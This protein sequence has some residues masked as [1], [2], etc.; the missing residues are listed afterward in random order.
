MSRGSHGRDERCLVCLRHVACAHVRAHERHPESLGGAGV[1]GPHPVCPPC[2]QNLLENFRPRQTLTGPGEISGEGQ[3]PCPLCRCALG[4]SRRALGER[5]NLEVEGGGGDEQCSPMRPPSAI[6]RQ[7]Q[8][9]M[10]AHDRESLRNLWKEGA[11]REGFLCGP[12]ALATAR[13]LAEGQDAVADAAGQETAAADRSGQTRP[14]C[15]GKLHQR[16]TSAQRRCKRQRKASK[17][18]ELTAATPLAPEVLT[19]AACAPLSAVDDVATGEGAASPIAVARMA[20]AAAER[21]ESM[22]LAKSADAVIA[23]PVASP[24]DPV[25]VALTGTSPPSEAAARSQ[26]L[27]SELLASAERRLRAAQA[28]SASKSSTS[29]TQSATSLAATTA[30]ATAFTAPIDAVAEVCADTIVAAV[31]ISP[32]PTLAKA[33]SISRDLLSSDLLASAE[34]RLRAALASVSLPFTSSQL[35]TSVRPVYPTAPLEAIESTPPDLASPSSQQ[36]VAAGSASPL[37]EPSAS[38]PTMLEASVSLPSPLSQ[39]FVAAVPSPVESCVAKTFSQA[40]LSAVLPCPSH[41]MMIVAQGASPDV[42]QSGVSP[43]QPDAW[44]PLPF[45]SPQQPISVGAPSPAASLVAIVLT[46]LD[47]SASLSSPTSQH[48]VGA[49]SAS[50]ILEPSATAPPQ[51]NA[52]VSLPSPP[53]QRAVALGLASTPTAVEAPT[54]A[55]PGAAAGF[56]TRSGVSVFTCV[57]APAHAKPKAAAGQLAGSNVL[58]SIGVAAPAHTEPEAASGQLTSC[59]VSVS[60]PSPLSQQLVVAEA[61]SCEGASSSSAKAI[62]GLGSEAITTNRGLAG[63]APWQWGNES[64]AERRLRAALVASASPLRAC[65]AARRR[66]IGPGSLAAPSVFAPPLAAA[67]LPAALPVAAAAAL[68]FQF[69]E[70]ARAL[71][72]PASGQNSAGAVPLVA[73]A[74]TRLADDG[75]PLR[76]YARRREG[77]LEQRRQ[78]LQRKVQH[79]M[80]EQQQLL[81]KQL[82]LQQ[83]RQSLRQ[84]RKA[85]QEAQVGGRGR[86]TKAR[87]SNG[88]LR[89]NALTTSDPAPLPGPLPAPPLPA[90]PLLAPPLSA[91]LV[92]EPASATA[93]PARGCRQALQFSP[94]FSQPGESLSP[95]LGFSLERLNCLGDFVAQ[96]AAIEVEVEVPTSPAAAVLVEEAG[97]A[98]ASC[99]R[100]RDAGMQL[101]PSSPLVAYGSHYDRDLRGQAEADGARYDRELLGQAEELSRKAGGFSLACAMRLW[102]QVEEAAETKKR[103]LLRIAEAE[104]FA[105]D[106]QARRFLRARLARLDARAPPPPVAVRRDAATS[107]LSASPQLSLRLSLPPSAAEGRLGACVGAGA[108]V[109]PASSTSPGVVARAKARGA[110]LEPTQV[111]KTMRLLQDAYHSLAEA[112]V[113]TQLRP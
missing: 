26:F 75:R 79:Q 71:D 14:K 43:A 57:A 33:A 21:N 55:K 84:E 58:A 56:L 87:R 3:F 70:W 73:P 34:R 66:R 83:E 37:V 40:D 13:G 17:R 91:P 85:S 72:L 74:V 29:P 110:G 94:A 28:E 19:T 15:K 53:S 30:T 97:G 81:K 31:A 10:H 95:P 49:G 78:E 68:D 9:A 103:T 50:P 113:T 11:W 45:S 18:W 36:L 54:H 96:A 32:E 12:A 41:K 109:A 39:P 23:M 63:F 22:D 42:A 62:G 60:Y 108:L 25:R 82:K 38:A 93:S 65:A 2:C 52:S 64:E 80:L 77:D 107:P 6:A 76:V 98:S 112:A 86:P 47:M 61:P 99:Q 106:P 7:V 35:P 16:Q 88:A 48:L 51:P 4:S 92:A 104:D 69:F 59:D 5:L 44:A 89:A 46:S 102:K 67:V 27:S 90:P 1:C 8:A 105:L 100:S 111:L 101:V 24:A 20:A